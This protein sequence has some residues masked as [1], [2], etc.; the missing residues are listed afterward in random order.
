MAVFDED[1]G[2]HRRDRVFLRNIGRSITAGRNIF[3]HGD[4]GS[5]ESII[6]VHVAFQ[7]LDA[8]EFFGEFGI[9][10]SDGVA[11]TAPNDQTGQL[12][13]VY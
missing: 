3:S 10:G 6:D 11:R 5:V 13:G 2:G 7:E 12:L 9:L 8:G 4:N 1:E